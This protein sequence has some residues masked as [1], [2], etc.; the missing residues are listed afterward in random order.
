MVHEETWFFSQAIKKVYLQPV[1]RSEENDICSV[2]PFGVGAVP[3]G[4]IMKE[5]ISATISTIVGAVFFSFYVYFS[6]KYVI[7][8]SPEIYVSLTG[9][10]VALTNIRIFNDKPAESEEPQDEI[11]EN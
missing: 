8:E 4:I 9:D 5:P 11:S 6:I 3:C 2:F 10:Q 1:S 7:E